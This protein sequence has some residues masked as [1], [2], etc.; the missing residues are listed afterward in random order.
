MNILVNKFDLTLIIEFITMIQVED[1]WTL[2]AQILFFLASMTLT[3][4]S[5]VLQTFPL[6]EISTGVVDPKKS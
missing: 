2:F 4:A 6:Y 3:R 5:S 1:G